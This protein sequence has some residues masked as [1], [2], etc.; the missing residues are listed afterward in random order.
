M[1]MFLRYANSETEVAPEVLIGCW[2]RCLSIRLDAADVIWKCHHSIVCQSKY[3]ILES[4]H[5]SCLAYAAPNRVP[6]L[7]SFHGRGQ[8][9]CEMKGKRERGPSSIGQENHK[10]T[11]QVSNK[12]KEKNSYASENEN[13]S[14][15]NGTSKS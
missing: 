5:F 9:L 3:T 11:G 8:D 6:F 12:A 7:G 2:R 1:Q 14:F 4:R 10:P 13:M 15:Y